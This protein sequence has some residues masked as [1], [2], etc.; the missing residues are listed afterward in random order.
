MCLPKCLP[1]A[2]SVGG[3]MVILCSMQCDDQTLQ[4]LSLLAYHTEL[5]L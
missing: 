1:A 5:R 2:L 4:D 3:N